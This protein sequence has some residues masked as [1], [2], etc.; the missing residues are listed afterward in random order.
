M[1]ATNTNNPERT[2]RLLPTVLLLLITL[3]LFGCFTESSRNKN[4]GGGEDIGNNIT[5]PAIST[6]FTSTPKTETPANRAALVA[7]ITKAIATSGENVNLNH[8]NTSAIKDMGSLFKDSAYTG[9]ISE[10]D[11]SNVTNMNNMF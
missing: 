1:N 8:I 10:W 4:V 3:G 9:D 6:T 7:L 2:G 5:C 11:V